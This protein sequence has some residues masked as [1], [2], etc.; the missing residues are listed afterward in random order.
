MSEA[1]VALE[2]ILALM[3]AVPGVL[4]DLVELRIRVSGSGLMRTRSRNRGFLFRPMVGL[5][6][7]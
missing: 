4:H 7:C 2:I 3:T 6:A 5:K 1:G